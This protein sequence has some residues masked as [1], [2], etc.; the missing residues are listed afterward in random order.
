M[1]PRAAANP[2]ALSGT[3]EKAATTR[4][5][6][7]AALRDLGEATVTDVASRTGLSRP[8][9]EAAL[10]RLATGQLVEHQVDHVQSGEAGGR[11]ARVS[12]FRAQNGYVAGLDLSGSSV[13]VRIADLAGQ[14]VGAPRPTVGCPTS[15]RP[16][17]DGVGEALDLALHD[18]GLDRSAVRALGIGLPG[19]VRLD[20]TLVTSPSVASWTG[21][22]IRE[23]L[24]EHLELPVTVDNDLSMA[25]VGESRLGAL[26][27]AHT[28]VYVLTWHH[29]SARITIDGAVLRGRNDTAGEVGLLRSF[30]GT[31]YPAG[32][33]TT[34]TASF[35]VSLDRLADDPADPDGIRALQDLTTAMTPA[36]AAL[37]LAVDP[38]RVVLGGALGRYAH[39][40]VPLLT[41]SVSSFIEGGYGPRPQ[42]TGSDLEDSGV[43]IGGIHRAFEAFSTEIYGNP[44]VIPPALTAPDAITSDAVP[45]RRIDA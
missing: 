19:I 10:S 31:A 7:L 17:L 29:V 32:P 15:E 26:R 11:P 23:R 2:A 25:A 22:N 20:G 16:D 24:A 12:R 43:C 38:D 9:V 28:G 14:V 6:C 18:C 1:A 36:V 4:A 37:L 39:L 42:F 34:A 30:S 13:R 33:L 35:A 3:G 27:G 45:A 5:L 21:T 8:T 44:A 41:R 40:I